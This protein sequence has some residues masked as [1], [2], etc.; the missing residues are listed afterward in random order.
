MLAAADLAIGLGVSAAGFARVLAR[1]GEPLL[2]PAA[3]PVAGIVR[4]AV[5][6]SERTGL[7]ARLRETAERGRRERVALTSA[8]TGAVLGLVPEVT[9]VV[10]DQIDVATLVADH[11]DLNAIVSDVDLERVLDRVDVNEIAARI[12]I[13]AIMQRIDVAGIARYIIEEV[14]LPEI[15]RSSTG[16][17]T[18]DTVRG[19]RMQSIAADERLGRIVDKALLRRRPRQTVAPGAHDS[20]GNAGSDGERHEPRA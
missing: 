7:R 4:S 3:A 13:D 14:D 9:T 11:V 20:A 2:G 17:I 16:S 10:L 6:I 12:D 19:M 15:I 5:S 8:A 1:R 18:S